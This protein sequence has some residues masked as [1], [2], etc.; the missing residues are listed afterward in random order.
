MEYIAFAIVLVRRVHFTVNNK[1][2]TQN[3][4]WL[5]REKGEI[6]AHSLDL[7]S[8]GWIYEALLN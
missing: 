1:K 3:R 7:K 6:L 2:N 4:F 8:C 5:R